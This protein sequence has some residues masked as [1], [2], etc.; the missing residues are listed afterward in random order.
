MLEFE[1]LL[2]ITGLSLSKIVFPTLY[3]GKS[4]AVDHVT[5]A[6]LV[7]M[8]LFS[9]LGLCVLCYHCYG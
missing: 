2:L 6:T 7:A 4:E 8:G 5:S 9:V 1:N 3:F